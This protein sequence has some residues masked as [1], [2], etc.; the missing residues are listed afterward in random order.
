MGGGLGKLVKGESSVALESD[1]AVPEKRWI[2]EDDVTTAENSLIYVNSPLYMELRK[3]LAE[4]LG[5][6]YLANFAKAESSQENFF[7]WIEMEEYKR[8]PT[9]DYRRFV[10]KSIYQKFI[11]DDA[12]MRLGIL[13]PERV[14]TY[15]RAIYGTVPDTVESNSL[16]EA[17]NSSTSIDSRRLTMVPGRLDLKADLF[18]GL[19]HAVF[20]EMADN[21]FRR[22]KS[23]PEY[24]EYIKRKK[25]TYNHVD[26]DDFEY[27]DFIGQGAFGLVAHVK[28]KSTGK[29]Y[30]IKSM[31]K[32]K[33]IK[34]MG[35]R[36]GFKARKTRICMERNVY[37]HSTFPFIVE[38]H[39]AFQTDIDALIVMEFVR[40]GT[41]E[42]LKNRYLDKC[43][44]EDHAKFIIAEL[45][46][47][48]RHL[49]C[50]NY[51]HRDL[52][53]INVLLGK[54][55][56]V[57]LADMGLVGH[58][59]DEKGVLQRPSRYELLGTESE[60]K[61]A[62]AGSDD[63]GDEQ[64]SATSLAHSV[65][66]LRGSQIEDAHPQ[67]LSKS[68]APDCKIQSP[69]QRRA[70]RTPGAP[71]GRRF[72]RV[73]TVGYKAPELLEA[74]RPKKRS[75]KR[76]SKKP[77]LRSSIHDENKDLAGDNDDADPEG[78]GA[79]VDWWSLGVMTLEL[80]CGKNHYVPSGM[81]IMTT[82]DSSKV[83]LGVINNLQKPSAKLPSEVSQECRDFVDGL[84]AR[85]P[86]ERLGTNAQGFRG[87]CQ[88]PWFQSIDMSKLLAK[89]VKP[90][91]DM[92]HMKN[93]DVTKPKWPTFGA[94]KAE[95]DLEGLETL[96]GGEP[97]RT[98]NSRHQRYFEDWDY[99][100]PLTFKLEL[101]AQ[102]ERLHKAKGEATEPDQ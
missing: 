26:V 2:E 102:E 85:S 55:G 25:A 71:L 20:R 10:A 43:L 93:K 82:N 98:I 16:D 94:M 78:Y 64:S 28:K 23:S 81:A 37:V 50:L 48:L 77:S 12:V 34:S 24:D 69:H 70:S 56:H 59:D 73:G 100:A 61:E 22:F 52:K 96:I 7:A 46:L 57:K 99:V 76:L 45:M 1:A 33:L 18:V 90:P 87:L 74:E 92:S 35:R 88:H 101:G 97:E 36:G 31:G 42:E 44:P 14:L 38:M 15:Q 89:Q 30:A 66:T 79:S 60:E 39:Y 8:I 17:P 58:I 13:T 40:G 95:I 49:H 5:Q 6:R 9:R 29:E 47:A 54:D 75:T 19:Q 72:T 11:K 4:P 62:G 21:T 53:P 27:L 83:E 80:L 41:V 68:D 32:A 63:S 86:K 51:V 65:S 67:D 84:L 3:A 91:Y